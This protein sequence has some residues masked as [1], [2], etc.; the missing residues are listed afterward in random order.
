M[1]AAGSLAGASGAGLLENRLNMA[2]GPI[3]AVSNQTGMLAVGKRS[4]SRVA[5]KCPVG[6]LCTAQKNSKP[7]V[8]TASNA[9]KNP[10][11][12]R[13][14]TLIVMVAI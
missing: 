14:T 4:R 7:H 13:T 9:H 6:Q 1:R 10:R 8:A 3:M 11:T 2:V 12:R 5:R